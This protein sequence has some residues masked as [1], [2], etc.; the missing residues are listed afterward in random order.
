MNNINKKIITKN[1][2]S[3]KSNLI[4]NSI[5]STLVSTTNYDVETTNN[6]VE[7]LIFNDYP[8][9][10][11]KYGLKIKLCYR[12]N[13]FNKYQEKFKN[14]LELSLKQLAQKK[15]EET[16]NRKEFIKHFNKSYL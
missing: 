14:T 12:H 1:I 2:L 11:N 6:S 7:Y 4:I 9:Q 15:F 5:Q 16:R 13:N 3:K 10:S 8:K